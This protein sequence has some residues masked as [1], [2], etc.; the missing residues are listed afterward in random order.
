MKIVCNRIMNGNE[1]HGV[2][3]KRVDEEMLETCK[4]QALARRAW[5]EENTR[6]LNEASA[7]NTGFGHPEL[8]LHHAS[9][10]AERIS[11]V[12][13]QNCPE[14]KAL[15]EVFAAVKLIAVTF[16]E[17]LQASGVNLLNW[18]TRWKGKC[19]RI[20]LTYL[21]IKIEKYQKEGKSSYWS[22]CQ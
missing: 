9:K 6:S 16:K 2:T 7:R 19:S 21:S 10:L 15:S 11:A 4:N 14:E 20:H 3:V 12:W 1:Y 18:S 13:F 8:A 5:L 17:P 22:Q